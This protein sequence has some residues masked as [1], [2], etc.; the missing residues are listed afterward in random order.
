[1]LTHRRECFTQL[2]NALGWATGTS[3]AHADQLRQTCHVDRE[4]LFSPKCDARFADL[5]DFLVLT[6]HD[7][8]PAETERRLK[9]VIRVLERSCA[10]QR[11]LAHSDRLRYC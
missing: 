10:P 7:E 1:M 2:R 3:M 8:C 6:L 5:D 9:H 4:S 11:F